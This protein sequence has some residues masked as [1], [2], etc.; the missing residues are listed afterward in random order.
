MCTSPTKPAAMGYL[1]YVPVPTECLKWAKPYRKTKD[2][3]RSQTWAC[4]CRSRATKR[5]VPVPNLG[6][7]VRD[8]ASFPQ[9]PALLWFVEPA[10]TSVPRECVLVEHQPMSEV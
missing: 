4:H 7:V 10:R 6:S 8:F 5:A 2:S 9:T 3:R 1:H